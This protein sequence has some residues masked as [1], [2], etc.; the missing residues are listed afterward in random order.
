[1]PGPIKWT[2]VHR[3]FKRAGGI[4]TNI[5]ALTMQIHRIK[6]ELDANMKDRLLSEG[7][8]LA[9]I[10][11]LNANMLVKERIAQIRVDLG[12]E[13]TPQQ[14]QRQ[15][16]RRYPSRRAGDKNFSCFEDRCLILLHE[17]AIN[18]EEAARLFPWLTGPGGKARNSLSLYNR[19]RHIAP[20]K[21]EYPRP[22]FSVTEAEDLNYKFD[23]E[24]AAEWVE[25]RMLSFASRSI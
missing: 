2:T 24:L 17:S 5:R 4:D 18:W 15:Q 10:K 23:L 1:M 19:W 11:T 25:V 9:A 3:D 13:T 22:L 16:W 20:I 14:L 6:A 12:L 7:H 21:D 8:S